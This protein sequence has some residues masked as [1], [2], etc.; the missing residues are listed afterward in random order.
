MPQQAAL[1]SGTR[2]L[3]DGLLVVGELG[4]VVQVKSRESPT[5]DADKER[6]WLEKKATGAIRQGD[7]IIRKLKECPRRLTNLRG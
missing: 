3:G 4:V 2:E 1:A 6:R 5:G 7:G